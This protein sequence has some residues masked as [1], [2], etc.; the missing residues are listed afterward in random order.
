MKDKIEFV[1]ERE[2]VVKVKYYEMEEECDKIEN[3][4]ELF[5]WRIIFVWD[6]L[7]KC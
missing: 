4:V 7:V 5:K 6:D 1:E 3:E 2:I